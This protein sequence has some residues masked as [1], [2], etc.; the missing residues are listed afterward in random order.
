M[1]TTPVDPDCMWNCS[2]CE[3]VDLGVK[4]D[5]DWNSVGNIKYD[6]FND[7]RGDFL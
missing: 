2:Y 1:A 3:L 5:D 7:L 4:I 6:A